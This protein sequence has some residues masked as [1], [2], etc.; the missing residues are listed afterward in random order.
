MSD[1]AK[2]EQLAKL[3]RNHIDLLDKQKQT[4]ARMV[5]ACVIRLQ[6][7]D[8]RKRKEAIKALTDLAD[9]LEGKTN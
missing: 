9:L 5:R 4:T 8:S 6:S 3:T 7:P 1:R 2:L